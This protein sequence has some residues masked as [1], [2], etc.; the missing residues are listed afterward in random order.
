VLRAALTDAERGLGAARRDGRRQA[1][2]P[3]LAVLSTAISAARLMRSKCS[4]SACPKAQCSRPRT[5]GLRARAAHPL[6]RR[7]GRSTTTTISAFIKSCRGSDS[8]R[9]DVLARED[10]RGRGRPAVHRAAPRH[11]RERGRRA[12]D[13]QALRWRSPAHHACDFI[14]LPEAEL[15]LAHATLY[16]ATAPKSNSAT[17]ALGEGAPRVGRNSR[18]KRSRQRC[19]ARVVQANKRIGQGKGYD[20]SH[21]FPENITG[22]D[23]LF[24]KRHRRLHV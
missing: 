6:R 22:Q 12:R 10:A 15:T 16:I 21:D 24:E 13:P 2:R 9:R 7:R 18:C 1:P 14:G 23:Y 20:Y 17:I 8:G 3:I 4:C 11:P 19:A 5:R